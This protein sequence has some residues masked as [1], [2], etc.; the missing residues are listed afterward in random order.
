MSSDFKKNFNFILLS[1]SPLTISFFKTLANEIENSVLIPTASAIE[2]FDY[3]N[4]SPIHCIIIDE[5]LPEF[6]I[7]EV[8]IKIRNLKGFM[9]TPILIITKHLKKSFIQNLVSSGATDFLRHPLEKDEVLH[10]IN[11][12]NEIM[13][14]EQKIAILSKVLPEPPSVKTNTLPKKEENNQAIEITKK[15]FSEQ[16]SLSALLIEID[17]YEK[18]YKFEGKHTTHALLNSFEHHLKR[19]I[20]GQD[21]Y[22]KQNLSRFAILMPKTSEKGS[23]FIAENIQEYF[24]SEFF[25]IGNLRFN[26]TV[27]IGVGNVERFKDPN[28]TGSENLETLLNLASTCLKIAK[29]TGNSVVTHSQVKGEK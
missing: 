5:N 28:K 16:F 24:A 6:H 23:Q 11:I 1:I 7:D 15:A 13:E 9:H 20:R 26:L 4:K 17:Q 10:R 8:C 18:L 3:L 25:N 14:V 21:I 22:F 29:K 27:S 12:S 2:L 19:L